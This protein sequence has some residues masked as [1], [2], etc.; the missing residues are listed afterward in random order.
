MDDIVLTNLGI[1]DDVDYMIDRSGWIVFIILRYPTY[2]RVTLEF[3]SSIE[4]Q[5]L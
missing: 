1:K 3:L 5:I 2:I 4:V